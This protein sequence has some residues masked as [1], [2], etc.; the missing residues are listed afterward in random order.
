MRGERES[1]IHQCCILLFQR[2]NTHPRS[3]F[4]LI[5]LPRQD[6]WSEI[7]GMS[8]RLWL[9]T[10][11]VLFYSILS[12]FDKSYRSSLT[13]LINGQF[14]NI[15]KITVQTTR[16]DIRDRAWYLRT[17]ACAPTSM[18]AWCRRSVRVKEIFPRGRWIIIPRKEIFHDSMV[19][20]FAPTS[21][22]ADSA[23]WQTQAT[24]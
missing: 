18:T 22:I 2:V 23:N 1:L 6:G 19:R 4:R 11:S 9:D 10:N 17:M 21:P 3:A 24:V 13:H 8:R 14:S 15:I 12:D 7:F 16:Y 5:S 20:F